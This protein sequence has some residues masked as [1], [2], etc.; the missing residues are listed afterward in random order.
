MAL[1][2]NRLPQILA[3]TGTSRSQVYRDIG[4]GIWTPPVVLGS[5]CSVWP[6]HEVDALIAARIE[7]RTRE[8]LR[9]LVN[10]LVAQRKNSPRTTVQPEADA[11]RAA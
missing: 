10:A 9:E 11:P 2:L 8:E 4:S 1:S 6:E 3:R 7:G 5:R